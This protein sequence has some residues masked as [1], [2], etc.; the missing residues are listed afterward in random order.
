MS[1]IITGRTGT[2]TINNTRFSNFPTGSTVLQTC[3]F[4]DD[5]SQYTNLGTQINVNKLTFNN[6]SGNYLFM[7]GLKRDVIYDADCSFCSKFDSLT[8]TNA[9][10]TYGFNH[11]ASYHADKCP[12]A[13]VPTQW[14]NA[15]ICDQSITIR[16]VWFTNLAPFANFQ[17]QYMMAAELADINQTIARRPATTL[18][19]NIST[20][21][22]TTTMQS[23]DKANAYALPF[24]TG[25]TYQ[26]WWGT[27][28]DFTH[29]SIVT[30]PNFPATDKGI[31][32]KFNNS[33][34]RQLYE[35]GPMRAKKALTKL[36]FISESV[37]FIDSNSCG[38]GEYYH[39]DSSVG[40]MLSICQSGKKRAAYEYTEVNSVICRQMCPAPA[41]TFVK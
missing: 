1:S 33:L 19:S 12:P 7:I 8:R 3:S 41:G 2:Y 26:I 22:P 11:I 38:N 24:I 29:L 20:R 13:L 34:N 31:I 37:T 36:D 9:T 30:T 21:I 4:C 39:N 40:R 18:Y 14:D 5:S 16:R 15:I 35:I 32:F 28:I 6:I 23:K 17:S 25:M 27:G 10:I